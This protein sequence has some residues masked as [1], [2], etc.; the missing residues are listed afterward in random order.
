MK[1][2]DATRSRIHPLLTTDELLIKDLSSSQAGN[3]GNAGKAGA[4]PIHLQL[5]GTRTTGALSGTTGKNLEASE[6][7]FGIRGDRVPS[8]EGDGA[9]PL[10][11]MK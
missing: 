1:S 6:E 8:R 3:A 7:K 4:L 10:L 9:A 2:A 5:P 11:N